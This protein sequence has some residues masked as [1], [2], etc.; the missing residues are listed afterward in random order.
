M[1]KSGSLPRLDGRQSPIATVTQRGVCRMLRQRGFAS[2]L[3]LTLAD[4][5]RP[6]IVAL[7]EKGELWIVEIKSSP[8][9]L[10]ADHKWLFYADYC[11][12]L[13]FAIPNFIDRDIMPV[14]AGLIV[15]DGFGAEIV[16]DGVVHPLLPQR[17]K[18]VT[19]RFARAAALRL[20][21]LFDPAA[22]GE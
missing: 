7:G 16:H 4:R 9:D 22:L 15:A 8:E 6:D 13:Y 1:S 21:G 2:L 19:L 11:D 5:R 17:R 10:R 20:H 3:E 14:E 18:A 12:R